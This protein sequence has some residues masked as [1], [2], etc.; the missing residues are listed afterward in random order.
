MASLSHSLMNS[1]S[2][3]FSTRNS[4]AAVHRAFLPV[5]GMS[6]CGSPEWLPSAVYLRQTQL[7]PGEEDVEADE[8]EVVDLPHQLAVLLGVLLERVHARER[9][10]RDEGIAGRKR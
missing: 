7:P 2:L 3:P 10:R 1:A 9:R 5:G 4:A 8:A 6:P